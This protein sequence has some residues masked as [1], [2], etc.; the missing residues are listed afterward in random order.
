M[1]RRAVPALLALSAFLADLGG[2]H[3][4]ASIVLFVAIPAGFALV[5]ACYG[6]TVEERTGFGRVLMAGAGLFLLVLSAAVRSPALVGGVPRIAVTAVALAPF[7]CLYAALR[8]VRTSRVIPEAI[9]IDEQ[10]EFAD[11][12]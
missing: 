5:V 6:D 2:A 4:F 3:R 12:A 8:A 7:P 9:A 1:A 10:R 11:A